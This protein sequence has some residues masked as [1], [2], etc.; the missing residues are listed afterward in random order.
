MPDVTITLRTIDQSSP[1]VKKVAQE[2]KSLSPALEGAKDKMTGFMGANA[3]LLSAMGGVTAGAIAFGKAIYATAKAAEESSKMTA[4]L[5]AVL[6]ST[7]GAAGQT[8]EGLNKMADALSVVS[9]VD[10]ELI[11]NAE[12]LLLTFT[13]VK[14]EA[15][16]PTMQAALDMSAVMGGD[17]QGSVIQVGKAM[18]DFSGYAAL[19][20]AGVS[21]TAEQ[22][23][24]I[25]NFKET[26]DLVGYQNLVLAELSTEF[27][28]AAKAM[29]DASLGGENL[30]NSWGNLVEQIGKSN[31]GWIKDFNRGLAYTFDSFREWIA[32]MQAAAEEADNASAA[33][34]NFGKIG[35]DLI[36]DTYEGNKASAD[37]SDT[38]ERLGRMM[39]KAGEMTKFYTQST[40]A[41]NAEEQKTEEQLKATSDAYANQW[42]VI[43]SVQQETDKFTE[44]N[45]ALND[46]LAELQAKQEGLKPNS[47]GYK[48]L[49]KDIEGVKGQITELVAEHEKAT[50]KIVFDLMVQKAASDGWQEGEYENMLKVAESMG[51][52]DTSVVEMANTFQTE[53]TKLND[54]INGKMIPSA[55]QLDRVLKLMAKGYTIDVALKIDM[56]ALSDLQ[57]ELTNMTGGSGGQHGG[58]TGDDAGGTTTTTNKPANKPAD[59]SCF[60]GDTLVTMA[61]NKSKPIRDV[62]VGDVVLSYDLEKKQ[63]VK[64]NVV[65]VFEH[66]KRDGGRLLLFNGY[67]KVTEEHLLWNGFE[68]TAAGLFQVGDLLMNQDGSFARVSSIRELVKNELTYNL[69]V[70]H[71]CHNYFAGGV[72]VHNAKSLADGGQLSSGWNMVGDRPGG[73]WVP[74]VSELI[75]NGKVYSNAESEQ[76]IAAGK[77]TGVK[78]YANPSE[79]T[80]VNLGGGGPTTT[81]GGIPT[82]TVHGKDVRSAFFSSNSQ[83]GAAISSA[84]SQITSAVSTTQNITLAMAQMNESYAQR[85]EKSNQVMADKMDVLIGVMMSEN[86]RAIGS[87]VSEQVSRLS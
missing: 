66:P 10:D 65:E 54:A 82:T 73:K 72:L 19:K 3:G 40:T 23:A 55:N 74:G 70:D 87:A 62:K 68:W 86:P 77:V 45:T 9:G 39:V 44:S 36:K 6:K 57:T 33:V 43:Q 53:A 34:H 11:T 2:F 50:K 59:N 18:N 14:D 7:G 85:I 41:K 46:K 26:N 75:K 81:P 47:Q 80:T 52:V 29:N 24:Q 32:N 42:S 60:T 22:I 78:S 83:E 67:L 56:Q 27:G 1:A 76:M 49:G 71:V 15:F 4:K 51:M 8:S 37:Y 35:R 31:E 63:Q 5:E 12:A 61:D 17:L 13:K 58:A 69:H 64:T 30:K 48:D 38:A 20:R 79:D 25:E 28:G 16:A 84:I 21:F